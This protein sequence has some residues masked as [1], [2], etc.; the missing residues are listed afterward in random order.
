MEGSLRIFTDG[1]ARG[2][3]GPAASAFA[4]FSGEK[5]IYKNYKFL[6]TA[7][8]NVAEYNA[9]LLAYNY[10]FDNKNKYFG[11]NLNFFL[12]SELV[13]NQ[14]SG[15]YKIKKEELIKLASIIKSL[16]KELNFKKIIYTFVRREKN[17][18]A[19]KL[20]NICI[21]KNISISR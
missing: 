11:N 9:V 13:V 2:N 5:L 17:I 16:E 3:P 21:D 8:N 20:V 1:G 10:L 14:L 7:T 6:G 12:D 4:I 15:N 18:F 19:D